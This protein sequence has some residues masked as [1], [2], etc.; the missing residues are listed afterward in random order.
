MSM[1]FNQ[2]C[3][4][5]LHNYM[6]QS[7]YSYLIRIICLHTVLWFQVFLSNTNYMQA[8]IWFQVTN[9]NNDNNE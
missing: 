2:I 4:N 3:I 5:N 1:L 7:N 9:I 6:I 8:M